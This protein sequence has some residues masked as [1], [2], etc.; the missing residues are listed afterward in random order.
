MFKEHF[1]FR[2]A[3]VPWVE[4]GEDREGNSRQNIQSL[5][6][7]GKLSDFLLWRMGAM[8]GFQTREGKT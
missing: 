4:G 5:M 2:E 6:G 1:V 7:H 8:G 3:I